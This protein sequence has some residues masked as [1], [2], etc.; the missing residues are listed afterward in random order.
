VRHQDRIVTHWSTAFTSAGLESLRAEAIVLPGA[1][2]GGVVSHMSRDVRR[3][4]GGARV[5]V[6]R[7]I[8][9]AKV[10]NWLHF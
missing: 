3:A 7:R 8:L 5:N 9:R 2:S 6:W 4:E 1:F 10:T